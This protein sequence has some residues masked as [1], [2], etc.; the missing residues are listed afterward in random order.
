MHR[1]LQQLLPHYPRMPTHAQSRESPHP[2]RTALSSLV[3]AAARASRR[4]AHRA[5]GD[6]ECASLVTG[7]SGAAEEAVLEG[8]RAALGEE[9]AAAGRVELDVLEY[10]FR[11]ARERAEEGEALIGAGRLELATPAAAQND[12]DEAKGAALE[13][14]AH[15]LEIVEVVSAVVHFENNGAAAHRLVASRVEARKQTRLRDGN[16][17]G[18]GWWQR[19]WRR[20]R[21]GRRRKNNALGVARLRVLSWRA[22]DAVWQHLVR[23]GRDEVGCAHAAGSVG[24]LLDRVRWARGVDRQRRA[25]GLRVDEQL[26]RVPTG[27]VDA[28]ID[29]VAPVALIPN[30]HNGRR[31][32]DAG[33]GRHGVE[34]R[35]KRAR[36]RLVGDGVRHDHVFEIAAHEKGRGVGD[37]QNAQL[38]RGEVGAFAR[39][40][41]AREVVGEARVGGHGSR[42]DREAHGHAELLHGGEVEDEVDLSVVHALGHA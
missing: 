5:A 19:R 2:A 1:T 41:R 18:G 11:R 23:V 3:R 40:H 32:A 20:R 6:E 34:L 7:R 15:G 4:A 12:A 21:R 27:P 42:L 8:D 37:G 39:D 29:R 28:Q 22:C 16:G 9:D 13:V 24:A 36:V 31:G 17:R 26:Q 14:V 25:G 33:S 30:G 35:A 38:I 10:D